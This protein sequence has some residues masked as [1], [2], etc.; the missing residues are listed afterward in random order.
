MNTLAEQ[1]RRIAMLGDRDEKIQEYLKL[2]MWTPAFAAQMVYGI[3]APVESIEILSEGKNLYGEVLRPSARC[4]YNS[5]HLL[6]KWMHYNGDD[7]EN[8]NDLQRKI[9]Y[10]EFLTFCMENEFQTPWLNLIL[11]LSGFNF[12]EY[13]STLPS[14]LNFLT[15]T[16]HPTVNDISSH[17]E[18]NHSSV[19]K[20]I[21]APLVEPILMSTLAATSQHSFKERWTILDTPIELAIT[22]A[23]HDIT[24]DVFLALKNMAL[25]SIPPFLHVENGTLIYTDTSDKV[26]RLTYTMLSG[27]LVRRRTRIAKSR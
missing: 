15:S 5:R 1:Y 17:T 22:K 16:T 2:P 13:E 4:F 20:N 11:K 10:C 24:K 9:D 23:G 19:S 8:K 12:P 3:D 6:E 25:D 18:S 26:R 27:R 14:P 7:S 21:Q